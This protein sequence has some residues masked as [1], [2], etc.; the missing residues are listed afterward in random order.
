MEEIIDKQMTNLRLIVIFY[1]SYSSRPD[2][3]IIHKKKNWRKTKK[4]TQKKKH[5]KNDKTKKLYVV[6][7]G[8]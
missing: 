3:S 8:S 7:V 1:F 2:K 5:L 4:H 6:V